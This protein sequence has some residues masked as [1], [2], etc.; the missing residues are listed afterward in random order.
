MDIEMSP[1]PPQP[2]EANGNNDSD[3]GE[4][5][6]QSATPIRMQSVADLMLGKKKLSITSHVRA[7]SVADIKPNQ[8]SLNGGS[9]EDLNL[10]YEQ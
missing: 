1:S 3:G 9:N 6:L 2:W 7:A 10:D 5:N 4:M 8:K